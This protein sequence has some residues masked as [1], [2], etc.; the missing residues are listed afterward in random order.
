MTPCFHCLAEKIEDLDVH[1]ELNEENSKFDKQSEIFAHQEEEKPEESHS[2]LDDMRP[3]DMEESKKRPKVESAPRRE[4]RKRRRKEEATRELEQKLAE[5]SPVMDK[6]NL[7]ESMLVSRGDASHVSNAA[8][9]DMAYSSTGA[10]DSLAD[11]DVRMDTGVGYGDAHASQWSRLCADTAEQS[12]VLTEQ[13]RLLIDP[14]KATR[15]QGDYRSGKRI[16]MRKVIPFVASNFRKDKIWLRRTRPSKR[17]CDVLLALDNSSS[18][19]DNEVRS[20]AFAALATLCQS[21]SVLEIGRMGVLRFGETC[22]VVQ[23]L[24][25]TFSVNDGANVLSKFDF[26]EKVRH[27]NLK[28]K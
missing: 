16:N 20:M 22:D 5:D 15:L 17:E 26:G 25:A 4:E 14:T 27:F 10:L 7:A 19:G 18:M 8:S 24:K 23:D 13:L 1:K 2:A 6:D 9:M 28:V 12:R 11:V 3:E 21:L